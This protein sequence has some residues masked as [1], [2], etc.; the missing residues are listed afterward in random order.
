MVAEPLSE[1]LADSIAS[2]SMCECTDEIAD[3]IASLL[4]E[5]L[6]W[7][8]SHPNWPS[9]LNA[10]GRIPV[11]ISLALAGDG[12]P[13]IRFSIDVK[14]HRQGMPGNWSRYVD[15]A[16]RITGISADQTPFLW[17]L[18]SNHLNGVP[19]SIRTL[20][21]HGVG[22]HSS[23]YKRASLY[24]NMGW[25]PY[26]ELK[27]RFPEYGSVIDRNLN[28][29]SGFQPPAVEWISHDFVGS[30]IARTKFYWQLDPTDQPTLSDLA[31]QH[32]DL[33]AAAKV[34]NHFRTS[35]GVRPKERSIG[36]QLGFNKQEKLCRQKLFFS[37]PE[38]GWRQSKGLLSLIHYLSDTFFLDLQPLY[39]FLGVF[40]HY[41]IQLKPTLVT[42]GPGETPPPVTFYFCRVVER[43]ISEIQGKS[44]LVPEEKH[45][46]IT[47]KGIRSRLK[48]ID[49][50]CARA[51]DY[52]LRARNP[53]GYW[54]DFTMDQ[55]LLDE[56][57]TAYITA[58][59]SDSDDPSL[60]HNFLSSSEWLRNRFRPKKG[61]GCSKTAEQD[62]ESTALALLA[63]HRMGE[64][65]PQGACDT[66]LQYRL[67]TG[68]YSRYAG[69]QNSGQ[70]E[71]TAAVL[72]THIETG[73][74]EPDEVCGA[75]VNL[76]SQQ[77]KKGEWN[78]FWW[79]D[80]LFAISRVLR[81]LNAFVQFATSSKSDQIP[82]S[83]LDSTVRATKRG[84]A[85]IS[86][87]AIPNEPIVLGLW[88]TSW[89][90]AHGDVHYPSVDRTLCHLHSLQQKDGRWFS[91]PL[92]QAIKT[93]PHRLWTRSH[94]GGLYLDNQCLITTATVI[95]GLKA[96][97][98]ALTL[99]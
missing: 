31:G 74:A 83:L 33:G 57:V 11:E 22:Y 47:S 78:A 72:L 56:W 41:K 65:L 61:W 95:E 28:H 15:Y 44:T 5:P 60:H 39:E 13:T 48:V 34:F 89:V 21:L 45:P 97:Q 25:L 7:F 50:M 49:E 90:A 64:P 98:K 16:R 18:L 24:F 91:V 73:T 62:A 53:D 71:I 58:S 96:L 17:D 94:M 92:R 75:V 27:T 85:F 20:M 52:I 35:M 37:C 59:L 32:P 70:P 68:G 77:Q 86:S 36:L 2:I 54:T 63:L 66:L 40:S 82:M 6:G 84:R 38:W 43:G 93:K 87:Q 3:D 69:T 99:I 26:P 76:L 55:E 79:D 81:A 14:D 19:F 8:L 9:G 1:A 80:N 30:T 29:C 4:A 10:P 67:P 23:G 12:T 51:V 42:F 88:S 46:H